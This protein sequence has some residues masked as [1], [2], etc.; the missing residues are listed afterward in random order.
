MAWTKI[1]TT[2]V[3]GAAAILAV[4]TTLVIAQ[5]EL[6][7]SANK[8]TVQRIAKQAQDAYAALSSYSD[9]GTIIVEGGGA[10]K[11]TTFNIRLQRPNLYRV[12]WLSTGGLFTAGGV[13][14]SEGKGNFLVSGP[15]ARMQNDPPQ[16]M[17]DMQQAFAM[18]MGVSSSAA[19]IPATFYRQN[20]G[21]VLRV[22]ALGRSTLTKEPDEKVG[23]VDCSVISSRLGSIE[24]PDNQGNSGISTTT[25]WIGK[26]DHL[27]HQTRLIVEG[28]SVRLPEQSDDSIKSILERQ[29]K[30]ATPEAIAA[31]RTQ[32]DA[33]MKNA[34]GAK[35]VFTE[36]HE[37]I[38]VNQ[39]FSPSD[40]GR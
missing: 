20:Y 30:P 27:I 21:D 8:L 24:L 29:D 23:A 31:W 16:K 38:V 19:T 9:N 32:M 17:N 13:I 36:T 12:D 14:W 15:I 3:V 6:Q 37:N 10:D 33:M 7:Y 1:K 18:A 39:Q 4:G 35:Y 11:K 25:L 26:Q 40:F 28:E 2:V 22:P 34:Q 5:K